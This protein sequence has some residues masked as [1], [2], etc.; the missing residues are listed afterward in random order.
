[1]DWFHRWARDRPDA[2][3]LIDRDD[4]VV[5]FRRA[6][7]RVDRVAAGLRRRFDPGARIG[8]LAHPTPEAALT[9]LAVP[10]AGMVLVPLPS[11]ARVA[12]VAA[13]RETADVATVIAG[14]P[15]TGAG[16]P[17][18][19]S[20]DDDHSAVFTSGSG[21]R[22]RAVRL[23]W[24]NFEA[25]AAASAAHLD[26]ESDDRWLA[27]LPLHHVGGLS[28]LTRSARQGSAVVLDG[29]FD[30]A[31][32]VRRL[33]GGDATLGSFVP[34]MID[35]MMSA[36]LSGAPGFR[37]GLVG[38]GPV[39]EVALAACPLTLLPTYGMTETCSQ[40]ATADPSDP[41]PDRLVPLAGADITIERDGRIA[42]RGPMV[43][44]G[45]LD[46]PPRGRFVTGDIGRFDTEGRLR[47]LGRADRVIVS[48][49]ENV[50]PDHVERVLSAIAGVRE[51]AVAGVPDDIWGE[52]VV[53]VYTGS[54]L[55]DELAA[56]VRPLLASHEL[57]RRWRRVDELPR[58]GI[59]KVDVD[60]VRRLF[61]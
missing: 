48:G 14:A 45:D 21:G 3:F 15:P 41:R 49:G 30:A 13:M 33:H 23:T 42:V 37:A 39:S 55:S 61:D 7:E 32:A 56:V 22:P 10:M 4:T 46:G 18:R 6:A 17:V 26:H 2:P 58:L 52:V 40:V 20:P 47:V 54:V 51:A 50:M 19:P 60:A 36:G 27:V 9:M 59:G 34:A 5:D 24:A 38:G 53:A 44:P 35:R 31:T 8:V 28:I 43:S 11:R 25:S 57:P 16:R 12:A 29:P 1:L